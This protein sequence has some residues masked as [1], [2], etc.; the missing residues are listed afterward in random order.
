MTVITQITRRI[1]GAGGPPESLKSGQLAY[2]EVDDFLY[3]G[4][5]DNGSGIAT[6]IVKIGGKAVVEEVFP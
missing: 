1:T 5:G 3:Y 2:N 6:E 4:K